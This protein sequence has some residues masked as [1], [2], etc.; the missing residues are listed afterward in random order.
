VQNTFLAAWQ[1][2]QRRTVSGNVKAWLYTIARN[3][4][5]D[6][7][8]RNKRLRTTAFSEAERGSSLPFD[9]ID[10]SRFSDPQSVLQDQYLVDLV[11]TSAAALNP[12][13]Y[14]LLDMHLR[15]DLGA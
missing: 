14:S 3:T 12:K 5:I 11:W 8:R 2:L 4:A 6:E 9:R 7:L 15:K 13:E 1:N 10:S